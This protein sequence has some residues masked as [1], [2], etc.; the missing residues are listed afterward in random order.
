MAPVSHMTRR[1]ARWLPGGENGKRHHRVRIHYR[2]RAGG[3]GP[4]RYRHRPKWSAI[5]KPITATLEV[6]NGG[7]MKG[8]I[9]HSG[10]DRLM[11]SRPF[12]T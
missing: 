3:N 11:V 8:N 12:A 2:H 1:P 7:E 4:A 6:Q 10:A 9:T 5:N